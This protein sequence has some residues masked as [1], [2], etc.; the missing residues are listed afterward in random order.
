VCARAC[1]CVCVCVICYTMCKRRKPAVTKD[2]IMY[3][4]EGIRCESAYL[5]PA[6]TL[7]T[8]QLLCLC[9]ATLQWYLHP[10][11]PYLEL[12]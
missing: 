4:A 11:T 1:V 6:V 2:E 3:K 12:A 8:L 10:P 7:V 5:V 9:T